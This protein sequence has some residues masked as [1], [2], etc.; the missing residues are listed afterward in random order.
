MNFALSERKW[1]WIFRDCVFKL[2][3]W[4]TLLSPWGVRGNVS[5]QLNFWVT[6]KSPCDYLK[7]MLSGRGYWK[8]HFNYFWTHSY[9][10]PNILLSRYYL[11]IFQILPVPFPCLLWRRENCWQASVVMKTWPL[12][13]WP[14][15]RME[16]NLEFESLFSEA[17]ILFC[18]VLILKKVDSWWKSQ[19]IN[20][21][22]LKRKTT[23]FK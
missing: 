22:T 2:D 3:S 18:F 17:N 9:K 1:T 21:W 12:S 13:K 20:F 19:W 23:L 14:F 16:K 6:G 8:V 4:W 11:F 5:P 7:A 10:E 15:E